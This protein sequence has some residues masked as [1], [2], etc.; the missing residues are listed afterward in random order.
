MNITDPHAGVLGHAT[1]DPELLR[2]CIASGQV[3]GDQIV[4]HGMPPSATNIGCIAHGLAHPCE[5]CTAELPYRKLL[6]HWTHESHL[7]TFEDRERFRKAAKELL[8]GVGVSADPAAEPLSCWGLSSFCAEVGHKCRAAGACVYDPQLASGVP[9][10]CALDDVDAALLRSAESDLRHLVEANPPGYRERALEAALRNVQALMKAHGIARNVGGQL[11][12][13][14]MHAG[15]VVPDGVLAAQ[16][17]AGC[18]HPGECEFL[19]AS[20]CPRCATGAL[21][22][23]CARPL[24]PVG[25]TCL[26]CG[27]LASGV[28]AASND[29]QENAR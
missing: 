8:R 20:N 2:Q 3:E 6:E 7:Q 22:C 23:D 25:R 1:D 28:P 18:M 21:A 11:V 24:T 14:G 26:K 16:A 27:G 19:S 17:P 5:A 12:P 4:Q 15:E 29:Q 9:S 10:P 13:P